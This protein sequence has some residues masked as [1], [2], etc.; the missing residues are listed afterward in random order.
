MR[1]DLAFERVVAHPIER[2]WWAVTDREALGEWLMPNDLVPVPGHRFQFR[3]QPAPGF[4]GIVHC[5]VL[6]AEP[7]RR[8]S[9]SWRGGGVDTVV[10]FT[11]REVP[12]G[13]HLRLEHCG[14]EGIR[15]VMVSFLLGRGWKSWHLRDRLDEVLR[16][17]AEGS[18]GSP[19]PR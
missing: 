17:V 14:F 1:R 7:P 12:E 11:L 9:F 5:E 6:E 15:A 18:P 3:T 10:T 4:D 13:T 19:P 2:V 8:L 16:R